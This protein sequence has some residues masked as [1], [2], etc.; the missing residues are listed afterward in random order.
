MARF[1]SVQVARFTSARWPTSDR[2]SWPTSAEYAGRE[3]PPTVPTTRAGHAAVSTNAHSSEIQRGPCLRPQPFQPRTPPRQ[4]LHLQRTTLRRAGG[5]AGSHGLT[6][7]PVW[8]SCA[9]RRQVPIRLTAPAPMPS[10]SSAQAP[11][12]TL[13]RKRQYGRRRGDRSALTF[14][15]RCQPLPRHDAAPASGDPDAVHAR[16]AARSHFGDRSG[17]VVAGSGQTIRCLAMRCRRCRTAAYRRLNPKPDRVQTTP[18]LPFR[19]ASFSSRLE[20]TLV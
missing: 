9:H 8:H 10:R 20:F 1:G 5:V 15:P 18:T 6:P 19:V 16:L 12:Q 3:F 17:D 11:T 2:N 7:G 14:H 4:P 13:N